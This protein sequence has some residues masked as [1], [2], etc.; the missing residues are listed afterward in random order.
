LRG[1]EQE[2]QNAALRSTEQED[3]NRICHDLPSCEESKAIRPS[4]A[5]WQTQQSQAHQCASRRCAAP[6][7]QF[8][9]HRTSAAQGS[10]RRAGTPDD[11]GKKNTWLTIAPCEPQRA[12]GF[13]LRGLADLPLTMPPNPSVNATRTSRRLGARGRAAYHRPRAPSL[14]LARSRYLKR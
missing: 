13:R 7:S 12:L 4:C 11:R 9:G 5:L 3:Q 10:Q 2:D 8:V 14:L 1:T 6:R